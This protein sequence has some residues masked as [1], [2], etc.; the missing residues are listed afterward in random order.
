MDRLISRDLVELVGPGM[1]YGIA[2]DVVD[3]GDDPVLEFLPGV[4]ANGAQDGARHFREEALDDVEPGAVLGG[5]DEGEAAFAPGGEPA[6]GF[7]GNVGGMI[8]EDDLD[9]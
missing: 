2:V 6:P 3:G 4:D 9:T 5:E 7:L 8:V 1:A